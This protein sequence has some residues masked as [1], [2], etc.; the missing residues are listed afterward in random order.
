MGCSTDLLPSLL[1]LCCAAGDQL[2]EA[3]PWN[4][5]PDPL[6]SPSCS[7]R[8]SWCCISMSSSTLGSCRKDRE[9]L[10]RAAFAEGGD[11]A[12]SWK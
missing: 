8:G 12:W 3:A 5:A 1:G 6:S 4:I 11:P 7:S 9:S 10:H 2:P